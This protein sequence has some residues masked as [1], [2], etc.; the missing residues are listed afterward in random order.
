[1]MGIHFNKIPASVKAARQQH[2]FT[3]NINRT[4]INIADESQ[5]AV[6][7]SLDGLAFKA[8]RTSSQT[9]TAVPSVSLSDQKLDSK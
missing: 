1:M 7:E 8:I 4:D 5:G 2:R 3:L 9:A 6:E